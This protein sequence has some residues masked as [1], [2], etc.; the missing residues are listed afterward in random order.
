MYATHQTTISKYARKGPDNLRRVLLFAVLTIRNSLSNVGSDMKTVE[1]ARAGVDN[2]LFGSKNNAYSQ[3]CEEAGALYW[4][5]EDI[6]YHRESDADAADRLVLL[7]SGIHGV[8]LAKAG[9]IAQMVY[10]VSGC[11]DGHNHKRFGIGLRHFRHRGEQRPATR[12]R[13]V[14][15]YNAMIDKCGGTAGLWD[16]WCTYVASD[17]PHRYDNAHDVS[18]EHCIALGLPA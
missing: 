18:G 11:L 17:Q 4:L 9:F 15:E 14:R 7:F 6:W 2:V 16:S 8:G 5:A 10:G 13:W 12:L 1:D 3:I